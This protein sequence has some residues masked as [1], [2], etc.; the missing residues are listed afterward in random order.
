MLDPSQYCGI[1]V[2]KNPILINRLYRY[3]HTDSTQVLLITTLS[4]YNQNHQVTM[5]W[6]P[7]QCLFLQPLTHPINVS[8]LGLSSLSWIHDLSRQSGD[9]PAARSGCRALQGCSGCGSFCSR[10]SGSRSGGF[11]RSRPRTHSRS[12][13]V[14]GSK[15]RSG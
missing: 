6:K 5:S 11:S 15:L 1:L 13:S 10:E 14:R 4:V 2:V 7:V 8:S 3:Y 12:Q 9:I